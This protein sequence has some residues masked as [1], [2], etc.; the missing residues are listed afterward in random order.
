MQDS[1]S[2]KETEEEATGSRQDEAERN[3][4]RSPD[5]VRP[6][7]S[8]FR[9]AESP[10]TRLPNEGSPVSIPAV[11]VPKRSREEILQDVVGFCFNKCKIISRVTYLFTNFFVDVESA[12]VPD[13]DSTGGNERRDILGVQR[14]LEPR[15]SQRYPRYT[16]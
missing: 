15:S 9:D 3:H 14:G 4:D 2:E 7:R 5:L 1:D 11:S 10:D 13:W 16:R 12:E 8:R 6:R